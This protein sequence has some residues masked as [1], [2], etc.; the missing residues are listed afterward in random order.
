VVAAAKVTL[1]EK[2]EK[3]RKQHWEL[4]IDAE[5]VG[6]VI[7][8]QGV[9]I[10]KIRQDSGAHIEIDPTTKILKVRVVFALHF[11]V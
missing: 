1:A 9:V 4:A 11:I 5:L 6:I 10:N 8:K 7:G 2:I 3:L